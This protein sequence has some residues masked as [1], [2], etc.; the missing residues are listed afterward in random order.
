MPRIMKINP[1]FRGGMI[2]TMRGLRPLIRK[3]GHSVSGGAVVRPRLGSF[4][5]MSIEDKKKIKE[6]VVGGGKVKQSYGVKPLKF[7]M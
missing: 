2:R 4:K 6:S 1:R 3:I 7:L 5:D